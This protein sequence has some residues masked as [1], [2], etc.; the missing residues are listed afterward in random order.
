MKTHCWLRRSAALLGLAATLQFNWGRAED[1]PNAPET[2]YMLEIAHGVLVR[3]GERVTPTLANVVDALRELR[4]EANIAL[5]PELSYV[6]VGDLKM[7]SIPQLSEALEALR[8]ASGYGFEW[9]RV[10]NIGDAVS[11]P[12]T[13]LTRQ[14]AQESS[15]YVLDLGYMR[16]EIAQ[17]VLVSGGESVPATLANV[18]DVL[19]DLSPKATIALAPELSNLPVADLKLRSIAN[20]SD[21]LDAVRVASGYGFQW[22][23]GAP[24]DGGQVFD[25]ATGLPRPPAAGESSLYVLD[26]G[27]DAAGNP[28]GRARRIV[29]LFNLSGYLAH[30]PNPNP[31]EVDRTLDEIRATILDTLESLNK[32]GNV[33]E[34]DL[35]DFI[36]YPGTGLWIVTG[37]PEAIDVARK[38][39]TALTGHPGGGV[40]LGAEP[41]ANQRVPEKP[42]HRRYREGRP[43]GPPPA[44]RGP[45]IPEPQRPAANNQAPAP[46]DATAPPR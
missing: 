38:V 16:L 4:P 13:G 32:E 44:E 42:I 27:L 35:P 45:R 15:L 6:L 11:D 37:P 30:L 26:Q 31:Q 18:V 12:A 2:T 1:Q 9:R 41:A 25:P 43:V 20:L 14:P 40:A 34:N 22:R 39:V 29:E 5:A 46:A 3:G 24:K 36:F 28:T 7:R 33:T 10:L 19:R 8:V 17:G 23:K 21:A